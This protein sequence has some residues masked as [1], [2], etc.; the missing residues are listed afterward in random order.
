MMSMFNRFRPS[1]GL[2]VLGACCLGLAPARGAD[3]PW[4][5]TGNETPAGMKARSSAINRPK[6]P[7]AYYRV[8]VPDTLDLAERAWLGINHFT[9]IISE[10]D[11]CEMR[12]GAGPTGMSPFN[13]SCLQACQPKAMEAMGMLRL[14]SGSQQNLE[15]EARMLEMLASHVGEDGIY[16]VVPTGGKK[17]WLGPEEMRPN[18]NVHGQGR[19][20]RAMIIWYQYTGNPRWKELVDRMVDG[21]DRVMVVHKD[22]YAYFPI[23][24]WMPEEYFRSCYVKGRGWKD[25]S[26]PENERGGEEGSLFNH[27]GHIAG[28]LA[29][30]HVLTGNEQALRLSGEL[31]KF[32]VKPK[33]WLY[34]KGGAGEYPGVVGSDHAHWEAHYTGAINTL[35][36]ILEYAIATNDPR[37]KEFA[38]DGYEWGRRIHLA[39]IGFVGGCCGHPRLLGL[40]VKL[41]D[42]G[43]GD[44]WEDVDLYIRNHISEMQFT[45]EDIPDLKKLGGDATRDE[46]VNATM[47]GFGHIFH[48]DSTALCCSPHGNMALFY[49]WDGT[50]RYS[51]GMATIHLLLNRASP[52]L[53]LDSY[54][55]YEGKAVIKNK[56]AKE[57]LVRIPVW[58]DRNAIRC[59]RGSDRL[60]PVWLGNYIYIDKLQPG[61]VLTIEFPMVERT[62]KWTLYYMWPR[63]DGMPQPDVFTLKFRGDTLIGLSPPLVPGI[64]LYQDR[65][66]KYAANKAPMKEVTRFVAPVALKW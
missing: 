19:M 2:I 15:L 12:W 28:A 52:W 18:A 1:A 24:G 35:R 59:W 42:A 63:P 61:D 17:P 26:E 27:Q 5:P 9:S 46:L 50:I 44:Y 7:G 43:V 32:L 33:F 25:T 65:P 60:Q 22:D 41:S 11:D 58:V 56:T 34:W 38:R 53:D 16:Y 57:V 6:D 66:V 40:A 51:D 39:R 10:K 14:M 20:L 8:S 23:Q 3:A 47:G 36:A 13:P 48:K 55:P 54:L 21:L 45:P 64:P 49:A 29:N 62:E 30:W 31:V 4:K 37:L